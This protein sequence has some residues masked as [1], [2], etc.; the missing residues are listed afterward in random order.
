M[1]DRLLHAEKPAVDVVVQLVEDAEHHFYMGIPAGVYGDFGGASVREE[2]FAG[3]DAAEG[4]AAAF[5]IHGQ[6]QTRVVAAGQL[7]FLAGCGLAEGKAGP[8]GVDDILG[9]QVVGGGDDGAARGDFLA[10]QYSVA[11]LAQLEAGA[12]FDQLMAIYGTDPLM[13]EEPAATRGIYVHPDS[14]MWSPALIEAAF[15][16][17]NPGDVA[18]P[19]VDSEGI[20]IVL[21][22]DD[23]PGGP[24]PL[25]DTLRAT[26]YESLLAAKETETF[27]SEVARWIAEAD[28][29]Y[30]EA[31]EA[32]NPGILDQ[33]T[34]AESEEAE[35]E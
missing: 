24:V 28:V 11:F 16:V 31:G 14:L 23:V 10:R 5:E 33:Y 17:E 21:Y 26:L 20:H 3:R 9:G 7:A 25:D 27:Q 6:P 4:D 22:V 13:A 34:E 30:T 15:S 32:W 1:P 18:A 29:Q 19:V 35:A 12:S 2:G 8:H